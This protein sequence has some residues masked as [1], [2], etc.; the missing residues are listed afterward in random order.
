[1]RFYN[2]EIGIVTK[3][4]ILFNDTTPNGVVRLGIYSDNNGVPGSLLLDAGSLSVRN[5]WIT[6]TGLS[7]PVAPN[8]YWL[9]FD[10]SAA[11]YV[12]YQPSVTTEARTQLYGALPPN[13]G[14]APGQYVMKAT[15][16]LP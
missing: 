13:F 14:E 15:V 12:A 3:L 7:L 4:G 5:G 16:Q 10:L 1:M 2:G 9:V 11:N 6:K 8:Y